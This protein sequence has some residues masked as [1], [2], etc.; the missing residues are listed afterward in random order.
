MSLFQSNLRKQ[1]RK[2][3]EI[4]KSV[5]IVH[6]Y[7]FVSLG[8]CCGAQ[9]MLKTFEVIIPQTREV[10]SQRS[11]RA[12]VDLSLEERIRK[13]E[14]CHR[15]FRDIWDELESGRPAMKDVAPLRREVCAALAGFVS[16]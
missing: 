8:G 6:Y 13:C 9:Y 12:P 7:S 11:V 16:G 3:L 4:L 1:I 14:V 10:A 5:K 15:L 2:L